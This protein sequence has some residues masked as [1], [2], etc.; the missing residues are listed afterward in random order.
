MQCPRFLA[1]ILGS[2]NEVTSIDFD[3]ITYQKVQYLPLSFNGNVLF[4][5]PPSCISTSS[6][7]NIMDSM[8]KQFNDHTWCYTITSNIHNNH[9]LTFRKSS[10]VGHLECINQDCD[11]LSRSSKQNMIKWSNQTDTPFMDIFIIEGA[12]GATY[13][14]ANGTI[15]LNIT[16]LF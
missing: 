6:F 16:I 10:C 2:R 7:K 1:S 15:D 12:N 13:K 3:K 5:L 8:D 4:E 9:G 14:V 11:F